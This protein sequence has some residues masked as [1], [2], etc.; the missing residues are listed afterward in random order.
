MFDKLKKFKEIQKFLAEEKVEVEKK[1][2][3]VMMNGK[4]QVEEVRINS[5]LGTSEQEEAVKDAMNEAIKRLQMKLA[6]QMPKIGF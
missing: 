2:C 3:M 1:G 6:Q 4:M 5:E